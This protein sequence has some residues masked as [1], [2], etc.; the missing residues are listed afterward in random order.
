MKMPSKKTSKILVAVIA[1]I[2]AIFIILPLTLDGSGLKLRVELALSQKL[3]AKFE[4]KGK[5]EVSLLPLPKF[6]LNDVVITKMP[7]DE[8]HYGD[9]SIR[10]IMVRPNL[11]SLFSGDLRISK[12]VVDSPKFENKYLKTEEEKAD[13][14]TAAATPIVLSNPTSFLTKFFNFNEANLSFENIGSIQVKDGL[15]NRQNMDNQNTLELSQINFIL[16]NNA[17]R[18]VFNVRG[19]LISDSEPIIFD[20]EANAKEG[21]DS[22]LKIDSATFGLVLSGKFSNSKITDIK[23][24]TFTGK[25]DARIVDLKAFIGKYVA[26]NSVLYRKINS[27]QPIKISAN[28]QNKVGEFSIDNISIESDVM[29]AGGKITGNLLTAIPKVNLELDF[30]NI[31]IDALWFTGGVNSGSNTLVVENEIIKQFLI[32]TQGPITQSIL[33]DENKTYLLPDNDAPKPVESIITTF[34]ENLDFGAKIKIKTARYYGGDLQNINCEFVT[35]QNDLILQTMSADTP[36]GGVLKASGKILSENDLAKFVGK[37]EANGKNLQNTLEWLGIKLQN[38]KP[39]SLGE[40]TLQADLLML[41]SFNV[42]NNFNL[43]VNGGKNIIYGLIKV[44]DSAGISNLNANLRVSYLD[45]DSYFMKDTTNIYL[46]SGSLLKKLLWLNSIS[47]SRDFAITFDDLIYDQNQFSNQGFKVKVSQGNL[48]IYDINITSPKV[49]LRGSVEV[50]ITNSPI[51][52]VDLRSDALAFNLKTENYKNRNLLDQFL[53]LPSLDEFNGSLKMEI[54]NLDVDGWRASNI[55]IS[56]PLKFGIIDFDNFTLKAHNGDAKFKGSVI[57][58]DQKTVSVSLELVGVNGGGVLNDLLG[59]TNIKGVT[60]ISTVINSVAANKDEF[61]KNLD[62]KGQFIAQNVV[63]NGFGIYDLAVKMAQYKKFYSDLINPD[64]ILYNPESSSNMTDV[65]G[66]FAIRKGNKDQF[67]IKTSSAGIN[68]V[69]A[70]EFDVTNQTVD[71]GANF[72][73][74]TGTRKAQVPIKIAT[75]FK[76]KAGEIQRTNNFAQID[77]YLKIMIQ[78]NPPQVLSPASQNQ[79]NANPTRN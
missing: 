54:N 66:A 75:N 43:N 71:G 9:V 12:I 56:G 77:E 51:L 34:F 17:S 58:K 6:F 14:K 41:P 26:K 11:F 19:S 50:D 74:I 60:N 69:V 7:T 63:I 23:S 15:F 47:T 55:S 62:A 30:N 78:K 46:S 25:I 40:Y 16:K 5:L 33:N 73:F 76:G 29:K 39:E 1:V 31:D 67:S 72:V 35:Q 57:I 49:D 2:L 22:S 65:S 28:L 24:S 59:I 18:Q 53:N 4:S 38:L 61:L 27:S 52:N 32:T 70:G 79:E 42:L 21:A 45:Y 13:E 68:S 36:S 10:Y 37:I 44:D 64:E 20:L 3:H 48:K 8:N